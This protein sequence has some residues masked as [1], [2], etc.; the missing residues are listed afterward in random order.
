MEADAG[1][2]S[3]EERDV[4]TCF[5][6]YGTE[7]L[8]LRRSDD[9][10]TYRGA[11]GGVSG[12]AAGT[13]AEAARWEIDEEVGLLGAVEPVRSADPLVVADDSLGTRWRVHPFL[14]ECASTDVEPNEEVAGYEWVQPPAMLE[15]E[16]VPALWDTYCA[17]AP[18]VETVRDDTAHGASYVSLRALEVLR[19][20]AAAASQ[21]DGGFEQVAETARRLRTVRPSMGVVATRI[22]RV[23]ATADRDPESVRARATEACSRAVSAD[24]K[25]AAAA[26]ARI[27]ERVLTLSRSG[28]VLAAL[29][30]ASPQ[31]IFVAES[32][33]ARE[34]VGVAEELA[35]DHDVSLFVDAAMGQ[36]VA[37]EEVDTVLFGADA[38]LSDGTVVNKVGSRLAALAAAD[39][40]IDCYAVCHLN[41]RRRRDL[42]QRLFDLFW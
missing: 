7:V 39:A 36:V 30:R 13:P 31:A 32:R 18:T 11:W 16:T 4:V 19:D 20:R 22:D 14:F 26:A 40:E 37:T 38:V 21:G 27:G 17:V 15:R 9:V 23:M 1:E 42:A 29:R 41:C 12:Y 5:L 33:P 2:D 10:G 6:R 28:T 3:W 25:A 8:L 35:G 24:E 34:G